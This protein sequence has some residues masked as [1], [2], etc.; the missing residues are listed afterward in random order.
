MKAKNSQLEIIIIQF[1]FQF[2]LIFKENHWQITLL[3]TTSPETMKLFR[4]EALHLLYIPHLCLS[5]SISEQC[6]N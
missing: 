4:L 5:I 2:K 1:L 3:F 6:G